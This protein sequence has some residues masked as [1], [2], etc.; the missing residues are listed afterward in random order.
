MATRT[1]ISRR[2]ANVR[3]ARDAAN[4]PGFLGDRNEHRRRHAAEFCIGPSQKRLGAD[5]RARRHID[6]RLIQHGQPA[7]AERLA[8]ARRNA[9][10]RGR[11]FAQ[12]RAIEL[13]LIAAVLLGQIHRGVGIAHQRVGIVAVGGV[14]ADADAGLDEEFVTRDLDRFRH[15]GEQCVEQRFEQRRCAVRDD[16]EFVA[17]ITRHRPALADDA[18]DA[19]RDLGQQRVAD[20]VAE[21][22]AA[23]SPEPSRSAEA[24]CESRDA[25][26]TDRSRCASS[27]M[28]ISPIFCIVWKKRASSSPSDGV[29][30][31]TLPGLSMEYVASRLLRAPRWR[32]MS[33][34]SSS[35]VMQRSRPSQVRCAALALSMSAGSGQM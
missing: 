26:V 6:L 9:Q 24:I 3:A 34:N 13:V 30:I 1:P 35:R 11:G 25:R 2:P 10:A 14:E 27:S 7:V 29:S 20:A 31:V 33:F 12:F 22:V 19:P 8:Q 21:R 23:A 32:I 4:Q 15:R 5:H 17:A 16:H 28:R 18:L